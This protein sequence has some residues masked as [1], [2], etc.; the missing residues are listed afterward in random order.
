MGVVVLAL[1]HFEEP[2]VCCNVPNILAKD[3]RLACVP[4]VLESLRDVLR[5]LGYC[6][7]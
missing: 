4:Q 2:S 1:I 6:Q 7:Q 3:N 5:A